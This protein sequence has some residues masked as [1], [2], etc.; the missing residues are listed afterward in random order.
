M[1][2]PAQLIA[3]LDQLGID[4]NKRILTD[5]IDKGLLPPLRRVGQ[6]RGRGAKW[7]WDQDVLDQAI[8]AHL[9]LTN[10]ARADHA[11][12]NLWASGYSINPKTAQQVW[13]RITER[14]QK[15]VLRAASRHKASY[16]G[17]GKSWW[18]ELSGN[19]TDLPSPRRFIIES[20]LGQ[21][22]KPTSDDSIYRQRVAE[23]VVDWLGWRDDE[24]ERDDEA[25]RR[26]IGEI[27][28]DTVEWSY[29]DAEQDDEAYRNR[30]AESLT[31][32]DESS[33]DIALPTKD[34]YELV[35]AFWKKTDYSTIFR[36]EPSIEFV[37]SL[38]ESE[39]E[40]SRRSL[41][42]IR[43]MIQH[44]LQLLD[45]SIGKCE[46]IKKQLVVM[47]GLG[48]FVAKAM[49][50]LERKYPD[51]PLVESIST[52]HAFVMSVK[53]EDL[54]KQKKKRALLS[55]RV[56][57]RWQTVTQDLAQLWSPIMPDE[58]HQ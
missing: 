13:I 58:R 2:T 10:Y 56:H 45:G 17:L 44:G 28:G 24:S 16:V 3:Y 35:E 4:R 53:S 22:D 14:D 31:A 47:D 46:S 48:P 30:Q 12:M 19:V 34:L 32:I 39:L 7:V 42:E 18:R 29:D 6:G 26:T 40:T 33:Y 21:N 52:L 51:W 27:F 54:L 11:L 36:I 1:T 23:F 57:N 55:Q 8:A 37:R 15:R 38:A 20:I 50:S 9:L 25:Y 49:L 43:Q 5:W 41:T